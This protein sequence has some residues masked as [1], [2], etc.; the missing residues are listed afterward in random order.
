MNPDFSIEHKHVQGTE[1][2]AIQGRIDGVTCEA[3]NKELSALLLEGTQ[4]ANCDFT[5]VTYLSS[6]GI[7]VLLKNHKEFL[8][9]KKTMVLF[10]LQTPVQKI[11]K[12]AGLASLLKIFDNIDHFLQS[13]LSASTKAENALAKSVFHNIQYRAKALSTSLG[14]VEFFGDYHK[15]ITSHLDQ[16]DVI[17][18]PIGKY[19]YALGLG[20][21][22]GE[23]YADYKNRFGEAL[24]IKNSF[25]YYPAMKNPMVD[26]FIP[27]GPTSE[28]ALKYFYGAGI[29]GGFAKVVECQALAPE[30]PI[31]T[32]LELL[33][34]IS[35]MNLIG[36]VF[37]METSATEGIH[38]KKV[39]SGETRKN[40]DNIFA[41]GNIYDYFEYQLEP[42]R[43][44]DIVI[45]VGFAVRDKAKLPK[46]RVA[47]LPQGLH[48]H[49]HG[50]SFEKRP[51][52]AS[53]E[54]LES[55]M[56][57]FIDNHEPRKVFHIQAGT[58]FKRGVVGMINLQA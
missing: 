18:I 36:L 5:G 11:L 22:G 38:L 35:E 26:Y 30:F 42:E 9:I 45:G 50:L 27:G 53:L 32:L 33:F 15:F 55:E 37:I 40:E 12:L 43:N 31:A 17:A 2:L 52:N 39:P 28:E 25:F 49:I 47:L 58:S 7:R 10:G 57:R 3:F 6:A 44:K 51:F 4:N 8:N 20:C 48:F 16:E 19:S 13:A 29:D 34:E 41:L 54:N 23:N 14:T 21:L 1:I 24:L 56:K 46:D